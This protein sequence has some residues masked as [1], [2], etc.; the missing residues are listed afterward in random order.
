MFIQKAVAQESIYISNIFLQNFVL[1]AQFVGNTDVIHSEGY[2]KAL[3]IT[4]GGGAFQGGPS[5]AIPYIK[6]C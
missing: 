6:H 2:I 5:K 1:P 4:V 3:G